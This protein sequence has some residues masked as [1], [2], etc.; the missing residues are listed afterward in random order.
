MNNTDKFTAYP[1]IL[2][3]KI[4]LSECTCTEK[5]IFHLIVRK[6]YG[7]NT[8]AAALSYSYIAK[9]TGHFRKSIVAAIDRLQSKNMIIKK[10]GGRGKPNLYSINECWEQ[11]EEYKSS[12]LQNTQ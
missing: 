9:S 3:E 2:L 1:N 4:I 8:M 10:D 11:W 6:T 12:V 5:D 7:F